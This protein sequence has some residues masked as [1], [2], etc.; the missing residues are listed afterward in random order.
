MSVDVRQDMI[1]HLPRL[2]R[3]ALALS[4]DPVEADDLVQ[5]V[6]LKALAKAHQ[7]RPDTRLDSW[8]FRI[9]QNAWF[10]RQKSWRARKDHHVFVEDIDELTDPTAG[11]EVAEQ[12]VNLA[13][14]SRAITQLPDE[15]SV[16]IVLVCIDGQSY[17]EAAKTLELPVGTVMSRLARARKQLHQVLNAAPTAPQ[18]S[19][20]GMAK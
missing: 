8:L 1:G 10:D 12:A 4:G 20:K 3:F 9:A 15:L 17:Q 16:L 14:V 7:F 11:S 6:C 19:E 5:E 2:R 18:P 13:E